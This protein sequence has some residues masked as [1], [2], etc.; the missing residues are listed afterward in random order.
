MKLHYTILNLK[1]KQQAEMFSLLYTINCIGIILETKNNLLKYSKRIN[2]ISVAF[3]LTN[4]LNYNWK[5][6]E[7]TNLKFNLTTFN[8]AAKFRCLFSIGP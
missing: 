5:D 2:P 6:R 8:L 3:T 1:T 7:K 4:F